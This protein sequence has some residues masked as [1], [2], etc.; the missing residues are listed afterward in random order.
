MLVHVQMTLLH[1][2]WAKGSHPVLDPECEEVKQEDSQGQSVAACCYSLTEHK[3]ALQLSGLV[4]E[5]PLW[6]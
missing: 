1:P 6:D 2:D 4:L 3:A 5:S